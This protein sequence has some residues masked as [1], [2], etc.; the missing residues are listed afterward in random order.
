M[1]RVLI[2]L[3]AILI[4]L[5]G[6]FL[7][8][9]FFILTR[10]QEKGALQITTNIKAQ[11]LLNGK[12]IGEA[13]L[14][15]CNAQDVIP[16]GEYELKI[17]PQ[18]KSVSEYDVR[19]KILPNVLTAVDRTFLPGAYASAY[20]ITLEEKSTKDAELFISAIPDGALVSIDSNPSGV[21]PLTEKTLP[22]SEHEIE[23]QKQG[24]A[25]KT[26][27]VRTVPGFTLVVNAILGVESGEEEILSPTEE[28]LPDEETATVKPNKI[29]EISS[30][31]TGFLR[32][33]EGA[34]R[35]F[36]EVAQVKPGEKYPVL[37]EQD[38]WIKIQ[39]DTQVSGWVSS[40]FTVITSPE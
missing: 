2:G 1:K 39:I 16:T 15:K 31:P 19:V 4:T 3:A 30:T 40:D 29:A 21:T 17:I 37:E 38:E 6:L 5:T 24:F 10:S 36:A 28:K 11:I 18:D 22:P 27:R 14:C 8:Y 20:I 7:I 32:V 25:K 13:P 26:I 35:N 23:I 34:G 12:Y 9:K 33:R